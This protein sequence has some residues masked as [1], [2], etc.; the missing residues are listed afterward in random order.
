MKKNVLFLFI[1]A[2]VLKQLNIL[3]DNDYMNSH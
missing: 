3:D 2:G 1:I